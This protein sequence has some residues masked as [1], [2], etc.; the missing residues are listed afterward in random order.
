MK[1]AKTLTRVSLALMGV[2]GLFA[3][4]GFKARDAKLFASADLAASL[5]MI[6][7]A[8][9]PFPIR[10]NLFV[11]FILLGLGGSGMSLNYL[12]RLSNTEETEPSQVVFDRQLALGSAIAAVAAIGLGAGFSRL[13]DED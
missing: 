2:A 6:L 8:F 13:I 1:D 5:G 12:L 9:L 11:G 7:A 10:L 4:F 3:W